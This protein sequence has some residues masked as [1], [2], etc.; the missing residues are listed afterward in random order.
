MFLQS[1]QFE[2]AKTVR[3]PIQCEGLARG[4][5]WMAEV[6]VSGSVNPQFGLGDIMGIVSKVAPI[7]LGALGAL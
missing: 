1:E 5:E 4:P 6:G 2:T 3:R 7:A